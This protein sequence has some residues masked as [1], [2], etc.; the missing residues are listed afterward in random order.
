MKIA[1]QF[2]EK[3]STLEKIIAKIRSVLQRLYSDSDRSMSLDVINIDVDSIDDL[4]HN[5][6][7]ASD[8]DYV[9]DLKSESETESESSESSN[10]YNELDEGSDSE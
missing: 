4:P 1:L 9:P 8:S 6:S 10:D 5:T 3:L 2:D 7:D